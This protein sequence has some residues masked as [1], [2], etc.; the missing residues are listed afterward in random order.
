MMTPQNNRFFHNT[1]VRG[2]M[3]GVILAATLALFLLSGVV[4]AFAEES[5]HSCDFNAA[6]PAPDDVHGYELYTY[7]DSLRTD[8]AIQRIYR[9]LTARSPLTDLSVTV[10]ATPALSSA[11]PLDW[12][13]IVTVT[14]PYTIYKADF[15]YAPSFLTTDMRY[16]DRESYENHALTIFRGHDGHDFLR[17]RPVV[18]FVHGGGWVDGYRDWYEFV[19]ESFTGVKGWVTVVID[20]RLTSDQVFVADAYCPDRV[21]CGQPDSIAHRTKA[22]WYPDNIEDVAAALQWVVAH[23]GEHGGDPNKIVIFGHSAGAHLVSLLATHD[24]FAVDSRPHIRGVVSMSGAYDLNTLNRLFWTPIVSQTFVDGFSNTDLLAQASPTTYLTPGLSLPSF[25]LLYCQL[26][27]PSL[28]DQ[29]LTFSDNLTG[30][31]FNHDLSYLAGYSHVDEIAAIADIDATPTRL[32][33]G[34]IE[35]L[36]A[37]RV[38]LP[39]F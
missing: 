38:Y 25:Y 12:G 23:V 6:N 7:T 10:P 36:L 28:A 24:D 22:A 30:L 11:A 26:E 27:A 21:T 5:L 31:G 18:F 33:V 19:A 3:R 8:A 13:E 20:Y 37:N 9:K 29:A 32:I 34:W 4:W 17:D 39:L 1:H 35:E 15:V 2:Q 14:T 16:T